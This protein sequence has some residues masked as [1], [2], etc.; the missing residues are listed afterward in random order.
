MLQ[1]LYVQSRR[2]HVTLSWQTTQVN[3]HLALDGSSFIVRN[4]GHMFAWDDL[5]RATPSVL[6]QKDIGWICFWTKEAT[7]LGVFGVF[8]SIANAVGSCGS[9]P[10]S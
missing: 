9:G 3:D 6:R 4:S 5:K 10:P 2:S 7:W 8:H 1:Q